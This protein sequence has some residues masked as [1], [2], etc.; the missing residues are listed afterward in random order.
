M[1]ITIRYSIRRLG[2]ANY[3]SMYMWRDFLRRIPP[4]GFFIFEI[5]GADPCR[6]GAHTLHGCVM[7]SPI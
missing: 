3:A 4:I 1:L 5:R 7:W 6:G 2:S